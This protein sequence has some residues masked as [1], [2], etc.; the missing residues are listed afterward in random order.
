MDPHT[1][2]CMRAYKTL[3]DKNLK[4][5]V[6]STAEWTKFSPAVAKALGNEV[7]GDTEALKWVSENTNVTV[8]DMIHGLFSKPIKHT[9]VVQKENIKAEM[10]RFL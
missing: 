6:Y 5:V 10:L 9:V 1:A 2:T 3:R 7:S 8:P 4:T